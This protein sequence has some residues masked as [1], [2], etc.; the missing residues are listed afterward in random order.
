MSNRNYMNSRPVSIT[1]RRFKALNRG[2]SIPVVAVSPLGNSHIFPSITEFVRDVEG[3]DM[4]QRRTA[5]RRVAS[6]GGYIENWY[7]TEL[8]GY[9][10]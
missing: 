8:R 7:V 2:N 6:G 10:G 9:C 3:L 4:S 5:S 1:S